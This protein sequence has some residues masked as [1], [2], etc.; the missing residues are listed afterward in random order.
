MKML[1]CRYAMLMLMLMRALIIITLYAAAAITLLLLITPFSRA[2]AADAI[3]A[4]DACCHFLFISL[5]AA[6]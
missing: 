6:F 5:I 1:T 3:D 2:H 4:A